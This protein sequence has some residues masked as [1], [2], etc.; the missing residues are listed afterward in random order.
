MHSPHDAHS[1]TRAI[2]NGCGDAE[3]RRSF[4]PGEGNQA[5][6]LGW[7]GRGEERTLGSGDVR[8][9]HVILL[10]MIGLVLS[11]SAHGRG[12]AQ[13]K[14]LGGEGGEFRC[15]GLSLRAGWR[16]WRNSRQV[17][18][19]RSLLCVV[20]FDKSQQSSISHH[21][22]Y[23]SAV[24]ARERHAA[25]HNFSR[26]PRRLSHTHWRCFLWHILAAEG[27]SCGASLWAQS[28]ARCV[29]LLGIPAAAEIR[30]AVG[31]CDSMY[32]L[33]RMSPIILPR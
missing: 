16:T 8:R 22:A 2:H 10:G 12:K 19:T 20:T 27:V 31:A 14:G 24:P 11:G 25:A 7:A 17:G 29:E 4:Q 15:G 18:L 1:H 13:F 6:L 28:C 30:I 32:T 5:A 23:G 3:S 33:K 21:R 9:A 26:V